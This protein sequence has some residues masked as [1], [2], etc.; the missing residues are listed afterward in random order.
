MLQWKNWVADNVRHCP[1]EPHE[2]R[3]DDG[4]NKEGAEEG[5]RSEKKPR[6]H[7]DEEQIHRSFAKQSQ[8]WVQEEQSLI[9]TCCCSHSAG[10]HVSTLC[11]PQVCFAFDGESQEKM[12]GPQGRKK[13]TFVDKI[14]DGVEFNLEKDASPTVL[15][16][17]NNAACKNLRKKRRDWSEKLCKSDH[18]L[19]TNVAVLK[20]AS[21]SSGDKDKRMLASE[22]HVTTIR[23]DMEDGKHEAWER[24]C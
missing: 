14:L 18:C 4:A 11:G 13:P 16:D 23:K 19:E 6:V 9:L 21:S 1:R 20:K 12:G 5:A 22:K 15:C 10:R 17:K 3:L 24:A 2:E 8:G 7:G